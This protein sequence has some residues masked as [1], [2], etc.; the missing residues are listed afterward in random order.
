[1]YG[2][3]ITKAVISPYEM[4]SVGLDMVFIKCKRT[5][6]NEEKENIIIEEFEKIFE[7][8]IAEAREEAEFDNNVEE[9]YRGMERGIICDDPKERIMEYANK[10]DYQIITL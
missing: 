2:E 8:I 9:E 6:N 3:G 1:M 7:S 5:A 4:D 10:Y